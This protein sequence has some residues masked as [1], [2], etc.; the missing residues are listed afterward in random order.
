MMSTL[1]KTYT[2]QDAAKAREDARECVRTA[3]V[4]PKSFCFDHLLHLSAVK[5]LEQVFGNLKIK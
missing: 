2:D 1:L 3:V 4:D 5:S